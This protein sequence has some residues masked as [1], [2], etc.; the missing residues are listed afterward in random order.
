MR[1]RS[2]APLFTCLL[3]LPAYLPALPVSCEPIVAASGKSGP[4]AVR[5]LQAVT[6]SHQY[7]HQFLFRSARVRPGAGLPRTLECELRRAGCADNY[8]VLQ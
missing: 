3:C 6:P 2:S 7:C 5:R 8:T 4:F 1:S